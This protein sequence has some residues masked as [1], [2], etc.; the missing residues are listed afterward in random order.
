[1]EAT[2]S[3]IVSRITQLRK[4]RNGLSP[5]EGLPYELKL[6]ILKRAVLYEPDR[7]GRAV[8]L[9]RVSTV[10]RQFILNAPPLWATI[11][12]SSPSWQHALVRSK[13]TPISVHIPRSVRSNGVIMD[14]FVATIL[15]HSHRWRSV[16]VPATQSEQLQVALED[17]LP[18]LERLEI[19][20]QTERPLIIGGGPRLRH[21]D[22]RT[23]FILSGPTLSRLQ[24][25]ILDCFQVEGMPWVVR[26]RTA[27]AACSE[28]L[29][30]HITEIDTDNI[31]DH[32]LDL[33]RPPLSFPN[34]QSLK[35]W[36]NSSSILAGMF[37]ITDIRKLSHLTVFTDR[38]S[39][40]IDTHVFPSIIDATG[41]GLLSALLEGTQISYLDINIGGGR[42]ALGQAEAGV[43]K[44]CSDLDVQDPWRRAGQ[45]ARVTAGRVPINLTVERRQAWSDSPV[46]QIASPLS[47]LSAGLQTLYVSE[48]EDANHVLG[49]LLRVIDQD[50]SSF[51]HLGD[52][53]FGFA[54]CRSEDREFYRL[55]DKLA[56]AR[57]NL[58]IDAD[59]DSSWSDT[60]D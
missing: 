10:W 46:D 29:K 30:L 15:G 44:I 5:F 32:E 54:T 43:V 19:G 34:L 12:I 16:R 23:D 8:E 18:L 47:A 6:S 3:E 39:P 20:N 45:V 59:Y 33:P 49:A 31:T 40:Y 56:E 36:C 51:P 9:C 35:L 25:L 22:L 37:P 24:I 52:V 17:P 27:L 50:A 13:G 38:D 58:S 4:H 14:L 57:P 21:L 55:V 2:T 1:M 7:T 53:G 28:L 60:S 26:L 48:R 41:R 11:D 42:V